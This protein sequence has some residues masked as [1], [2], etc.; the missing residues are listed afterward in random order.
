[1]TPHRRFL[2]SKAS[3]KWVSEYPDLGCA[4]CEQNEK[5]GN[6]TKYRY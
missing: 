3:C 4:E 1:M 2:Y 5:Q 6:Y